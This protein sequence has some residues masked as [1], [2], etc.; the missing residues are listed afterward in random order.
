[1]S[2]QKCSETAADEPV[3][4]LALFR[5]ENPLKSR[6]DRAFLK[7]IPQAPG[8]YWMLGRDGEV[9]YVGK[10]KSLAARLRSYRTGS[11]QKLAAKTWRLALAT[12]RIHWQVT[13]SETEAL[14][15]ENRLLRELKPPFNVVNTRPETYLYIAHRITNHGFELR[16]VFDLKELES[17]R[18]GAGFR[19]HGAFKGITHITKAYA[20]LARWAWAFLQDSTAWPQPLARKVAP[21]RVHIEAR[22]EGSVEANDLLE[23]CDTHLTLLLSGL[24]ALPEMVVPEEEPSL[25]LQSLW[26]SDQLRLAEFFSRNAV[27]LKRLRETRGSPFGI[28]A[29]EE[30]DD[31]VVLSRMDSTCLGETLP[32]DFE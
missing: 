4:Q 12:E 31:L 2:E 3:E 9:L 28:V 20:S 13:R 21:R 8:V 19:V 1:M 29:Q 5:E 16:L 7:S 22:A 24:F 10:A 11:R 30:V 26:L 32:L 18:E 27:R 23:R 25:F 14:L 6:F 15:L 17:S